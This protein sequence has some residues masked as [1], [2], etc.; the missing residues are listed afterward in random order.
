M[1]DYK[2]DQDRFLDELGDWLRNARRKDLIGQLAALRT[3]KIAD[4]LWD[5]AFAFMS[6]EGY[7]KAH[8][9]AEMCLSRAIQINMAR[10]GGPTQ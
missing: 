7:L 9:F 4:R 6:S 2:R 1:S 3:K 10:A 5:A 8:A